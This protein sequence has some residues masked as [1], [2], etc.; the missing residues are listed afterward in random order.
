MTQGAAI[1]PITLEVIRN[2]LSA[3]PEQI[4]AN[5]TRTAFS[6]LIYE[7]KDFAVGLVDIECRLISQG[8]GGI[9]LFVANILGAAVEHGIRFY[10][11][12]GFAHG[13]VVICNYS[14]VLG[15]HLNNVVMYTTV[16]AQQNDAMPVAFIAI[17]AHWRDVGG[18]EVGSS[19]T[20][21]TVSIFQEG[22]RSTCTQ[23]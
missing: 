11:K 22:V 20:N 12:E 21:D 18:S 4:E 3:I 19:A 8:K 7:Y 1:D 5:I 10:G 9:P 15:Q 14:G 13:D 2:K 17:A 16:F 23:I 6:P